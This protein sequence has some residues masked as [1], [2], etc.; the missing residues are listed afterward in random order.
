MGEMTNFLVNDDGSVTVGDKP[1]KDEVNILDIFRIEKAKGGPF[2]SRRMKKRALKYAKQANVP[3]HV[4]EKLMLDNYPNEFANYP[5]TTWLIVWFVA[6]FLFL[7]GTVILTINTVDQFGQ[8]LNATRQYNAFKDR[9]PIPDWSITKNEGEDENEAWNRYY[10]SMSIFSYEES[11]QNKANYRDTKF[12]NFLPLLLS[13]IACLAITVIS[14][15]QYIKLR[16]KV[17]ETSNKDQIIN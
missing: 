16:K 15:R 2:A 5:K 13:T 14:I 9:Q 10:N 1:S 3:E 17:I 12:S 6:A 11:L 4:V 8:Y 7:G